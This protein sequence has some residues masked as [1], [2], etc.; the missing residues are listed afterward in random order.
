MYVLSGRRQWLIYSVYMLIFK[1]ITTRTHL[2]YLTVCNTD[3][4]RKKI[5]RDE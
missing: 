1:Y 4:S 2:N 3:K 5:F